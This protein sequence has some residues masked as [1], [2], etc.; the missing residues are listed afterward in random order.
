MNNTHSIIYFYSE[1]DFRL[2]VDLSTRQDFFF[3]VPGQKSDFGVRYGE[4]RLLQGF[5]KKTDLEFF[6]FLANKI[7][8][9]GEGRKMKN[10]A[11]FNV[12]WVESR[13]R[14]AFFP[15]IDQIIFGQILGS[16]LA[17][18]VLGQKRRSQM[19]LARGVQ[20]RYPKK[21]TTS[22]TQNILG[23]SPRFLR[24]LY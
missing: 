4:G 6:Q 16:F 22:G 8:A 23:R 10:Q 13:M 24:A 19:S 14:S 17:S 11:K 1:F 5:I 7:G 12:S 3:S 21:S 15:K 9:A 18:F 20:Y 2:K